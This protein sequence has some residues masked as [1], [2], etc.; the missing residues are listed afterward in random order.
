MENEIDKANATNNNP[1]PEEGAPT[2]AAEQAL[3]ALQKDLQAAQAKAAEYLDGWQRSRA[4]LANY[5]RRIEKEQSEIYQNAAGRIIAR[6]LEVLDDFDRAMK[7][8]PAVDN[9][10]LAKWAD[11][12]ALIYR[13]L[14]NVLDAEGVTRIEAE[15]KEF[16]PTVHE[17]VTQEPCDTHPTGHV[18]AVV[19]Q[20][21]KLGDK[22]IRPALV[23]VAQ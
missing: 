7:E 15:G 4:E 20:G 23:R 18:I 21:Y 22:V 19:R 3:E 16:D 17:A 9:G 1:A 14:Q 8:R 12:T 11:G 10:D 2:P 5:K 6:Y 13:K